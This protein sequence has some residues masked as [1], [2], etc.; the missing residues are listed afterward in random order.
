VSI[1]DPVEGE[2]TQSKLTVRVDQ[3]WIEPAK[4]YATRHRTSL[5]RLISEYLRSLATPVTIPRPGR[6]RQP[7]EIRAVKGATQTTIVVCGKWL[8]RGWSLQEQPHAGLET[9]AIP[10]HRGRWA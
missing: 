8:T 6:S 4:A 3:R 7:D 5:S 9:G 10:M 1:E 2:M